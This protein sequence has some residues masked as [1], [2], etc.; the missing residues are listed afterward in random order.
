[1]VVSDHAHHYRQHLGGAAKGSA[2]PLDVSNFT[3]S[4]PLSA[5]KQ[6]RCK[7]GF[8]DCPPPEIVLRTILMHGHAEFQ[9][10]ITA[11]IETGKMGFRESSWTTAILS[12]RCPLWVK[13]RHVQC[14]NPCPLYT[15][16]RRQMRHMECP[17]GTN[18]G[19]YLTATLDKLLRR[20]R[21]CRP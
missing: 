13:S 11:G 5:V 20:V 18:R 12:R 7:S 9:S 17:L 15:R 8:H 16:K 4:R 1:M 6:R 21:D 14:A 3:K 10:A 2:M 19:Q